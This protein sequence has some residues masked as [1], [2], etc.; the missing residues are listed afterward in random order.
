MCVSGYYNQS[1]EPV[2]HCQHSDYAGQTKQP[3][4]SVPAEETKNKFSSLRS[5]DDLWVPP[6]PRPKFNEHEI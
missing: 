5:P 2:Q 3:K 6:S 4:I 1:L